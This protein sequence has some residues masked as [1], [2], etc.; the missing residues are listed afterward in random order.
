MSLKTLLG[1]IAN[2]MRRHTEPGKRDMDLADASLVWLADK[3]GLR[4]IMTVDI[5]DFNRYRLP[6]GS[7]FVLL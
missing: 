3:I 5:G 7:A 4:E 2:W 6:D 1:N